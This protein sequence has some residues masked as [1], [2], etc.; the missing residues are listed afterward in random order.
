MRYLVQVV[1][2]DGNPID[3]AKF[4]LAKD[5]VVYANSQR[6]P[7]LKGRVAW[8]VVD[9]DDPEINVEAAVDNE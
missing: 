9:T 2:P 7:E 3:V 4:A 5:A 1:Y 6:K 8:V